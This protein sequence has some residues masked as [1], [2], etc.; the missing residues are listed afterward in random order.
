MEHRA[1]I[2]LLLICVPHRAHLS[3]N[4]MEALLPHL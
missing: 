3:G 2:V 1:L 4:S